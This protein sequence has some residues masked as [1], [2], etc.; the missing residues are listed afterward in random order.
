MFSQTGDVDKA[1]KTR[2]WDGVE[3]V[4]VDRGNHLIR[5]MKFSDNAFQL[6]TLAGSPPAPPL[7]FEPLPGYSDGPGTS[8][9]FNDP[10]DA[11]VV[12]TGGPRGV[13]VIVA[14]GGNH[15]LRGVEMATGE[16][17]TVAGS[18][19]LPGH[20]DGT[21]ATAVFSFPRGLAVT[22]S[23]LVLIADQGNH[24]IRA[25]DFKSGEVTTIA[26]SIVGVSGMLDGVGQSAF[27]KGPVRIVMY[28]SDTAIVSDFG[29]SAVRF[30]DFNTRAVTTA[31][32]T[33][34]SGNLNGDGAV[35]TLGSPIG[36]AVLDTTILIA[37]AE[38]DHLR[39]V[40]TSS[41]AAL[42]DLGVF[43]LD[44]VD[45]VEGPLLFCP[46]HT[47]QAGYGEWLGT[48]LHLYVCQDKIVAAK[49][50]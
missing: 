32:G 7:S 13:I 48:A 1:S 10:S 49:T 3:A 47:G 19:D 30:V 29:N 2:N 11:V 42:R 21:L 28:A 46:G 40:T 31:A 4:I 20:R 16:V 18:G 41:S 22:D 33:G 12:S 43:E 9:R 15:R 6:S 25:L 38:L 45:G 14:D 5:H 50:E 44:S 35:A 27:F 36:L 23:G 34:T 8:A 37:D 39:A 17:F 24:A 26:G